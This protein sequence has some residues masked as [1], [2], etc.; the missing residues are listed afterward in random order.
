MVPTD[1][2]ENGPWAA[3][4]K[5]LVERYGLTW[6]K[7]NPYRQPCSHNFNGEGCGDYLRYVDFLELVNEPNKLLWPQRQPDSNNGLLVMPGQVALMF[8]TSKA[9]LDKRNA[10]LVNAEPRQL[11]AG[12]TTLKL[13]GPATLDL[14]DRKD[15]KRYRETAYDQF[16]TSLFEWIGAMR[17]QPGPHFAW[18][19]H[20]YADME[21]RRDERPRT[22][23]SG[24]QKRLLP[25]IYK[26]TNSAAW[27]RALLA[28]GVRGYKWGGWPGGNQQVVL[29]TEGGVRLNEAR[30]FVTPRVNAE[31]LQARWVDRN[32]NLM[33][34]G[35]LSAGIG[36]FTNYLIYSDPCTDT[37]L[38]D[39]AGSMTGF[40]DRGAGC[41]NSYFTGAGGGERPLLT[42]WGRL[43]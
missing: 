33:K 36:M 23:T 15:D 5:F 40:L 21:D 26:K 13:L 18:S 38:R 3:L 34:T 9:V 35:P 32:F 30:K 42:T 4:I 16:N 29:L 31:T 6:D 27:T 7:V 20:N 41:N 8:R 10:E 19:H 39:Y 37:G 22:T 24:G 25:P 28:V 12:D 1:L 17:F 11:N 43:Q 2:G 14:S